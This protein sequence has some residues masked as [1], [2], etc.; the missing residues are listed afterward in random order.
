MI[1]ATLSANAGAFLLATVPSLP[2]LCAGAVFSST[3]KRLVINLLPL[4]PLPALV[5]ALLMPEEALI[6][7]PWFFMGSVLHLDAIGRIFLAAAALVWLVASMDA[8]QRLAGKPKQGRFAAFFLTAMAGNFGLIAAS[9]RLGFYFFFALMSLSAWGLIIHHR[10]SWSLAAGRRYLIAVMVGEVALFIALALLT[11]QGTTSLP[12][13]GPTLAV[14]L[15]IGFGVKIGAV[16]MHGWMPAAYGVTPTPAVAALAGAMANAGLL[17]WLRFLL[18]IAG[19]IP[20]A[21]ATSFCLV[22]ATAAI[23]GVMKGLGENEAG[24]I[25]GW[26]SISQM[27]LAT[28]LVG[29]A[30]HGERH[31]EAAMVVALFAVHHGFAKSS[32]FLNLGRLRDAATHDKKPWWPRAG[33]WLASLSLAGFP[34]SSGAV[35]KSAMKIFLS[36]DL[37]STSNAIHLL[38]N[39]N[40]TQYPAEAAR[41]SPQITAITPLLPFFLSLA[42]IATTVLVLHFLHHVEPSDEDQKCPSES[43]SSTALALATCLVVI[44][45]WFWPAQHAITFTSFWQSLWPVLTG[46]FIFILIRQ[47]LPLQSPFSVISQ[48]KYAPSLLERYGSVIMDVLTVAD[49]KTTSIRSRSTPLFIAAGQRLAAGLGIRQTEKILGRWSVAGLCYLLLCLTLLLTLLTG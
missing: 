16:P 28:I 32:L 11:T 39:Q 10:H 25:L 21:T 13:V 20:T 3:G 17:G 27:G 29:A 22:G 45:L 26:S 18:P 4:A 42:S 23:F 30:L 14:A 43:G 15:F 7:A 31:Q 2:L 37:A 34:L 24:R 33:L 12:W 5:A 1:P 46:W 49:R 40:Q 44:P 48:K 41:F 6:R 19:Q 35:S 47:R 36:R 8:R 9:D 38:E